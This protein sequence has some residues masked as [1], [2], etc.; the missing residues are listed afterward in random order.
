MKFS[1]LTILMTFVLNFAISMLIYPQF[2]WEQLPGLEGANADAL[3]SNSAGE[4]F[5]ATSSS[6]IFKSTDNG[7]S[8]VEKNNG[9]TTSNV[10]SLAVNNNDDIFAGTFNSGIYRSTDNGESWTQINTGLTLLNIRT[11]VINNDSGYVF[12]CSGSTPFSG[13]AFRSS[14]N[15]DSWTAIN[16][17]L[18]FGAIFSLA[19]DSSNYVYAGSGFNGGVYF[20][21]N[22]GQNW[23]ASGLTNQTVL[24]LTIDKAN[25][26][27]YAGT[28][29]VV[30]KS[31]DGGLTWNPTGLSGNIWALVTN[32]IGG[33]FVGT[34]SGSIYS[35]S[36][37]GATWHNLINELTIVQDILIAQNGDL[38]AAVAGP[39]IFHSTDNGN[40]WENQTE[41]FGSIDVNSINVAANG[42]IFAGAGMVYRSLDNGQS[43]TYVKGGRGNSWY[44]SIV[45][46]SQGTVFAANAGLSGGYWIHRSTDNGETWTKINNGVTDS[47]IWTIALDSMDNIFIGTDGGIF[48]STNKGDDWVPMN[49]GLTSN[50]VHALVLKDNNTLFA[51]TYPSGLFRSTDGGNNWVSVLNG[52]I[53]SNWLSLAVDSIGNIYTGSASGGSGI[54]RSTDNGDSWIKADSGITDLT[55]LSLTTKGNDIFAGTETGGVF[56]SSDSGEFWTSMNEGM[57]SID[58]INSLYIADN[59]IYA[60]TKGLWRR[61]LYETIPSAP[62]GL[63]AIADTFTVDLNW[64]DNSDNE[65]GFKIERKDDSLSVPGLWTLIDSVGAD[66]TTFT[67]IGLTPNTVYSYKVYAYNAVGNSESDSVQTVTIIPVELTSFTASVTGNR[68]N[69]NWSTV[70]ETNN[71]GFEIQRAVIQT[72]PGSGSSAPEWTAVSFVSGSGTTTEPRSY[73]FTEDNMAVGKY[74]YR[75]KQIDLDGSYNYSNALEV[76][77][78]VPLQYSLKQNYPNPFNPATTLG[79]SLKTEARVTLSIY[80]VLGEKVASLLNRDEMNAG[81]H[82]VRFDASEMP[83]GIYFYTLEARG[84]DGSSFISSKKMMLLK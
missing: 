38:F 20:S 75:L 3:V 49:S 52:I 73:S 18:P 77:I 37:Y 56:R 6:G 33:V 24:S 15:G 13:G 59:Y 57:Q 70:T 9:L 7:I 12:A 39:G 45:T 48:Y 29:T 83:T 74:S 64:T 46:N 40:N 42:S 62:T 31:T 82:S 26:I 30:L 5:A 10:I 61:I 16:S 84:T 35:S 81:E 27:I 22:N 79:F 63:F 71:R 14:N 51:G 34:W 72:Q 44:N 69:L 80:N 76:S 47:T 41:G 53:G 68:V 25:D 67:D 55:I 21:T 65:L 32:N 1:K 8:W 58:K 2:L 50:K 36:D 23:I 43:W 28:Y 11:I 54:Y 60:G 78:D 4:I 19:I 17:G 66:V